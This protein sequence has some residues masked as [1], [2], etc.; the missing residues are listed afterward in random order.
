MKASECGLLDCISKPEQFVVPIYQRSYSWTRE[1]CNQLLRDIIRAGENDHV[2]TH[3]IGA[4]VYIEKGL[5]QVS[6]KEPNLIIDGQQRLTTT[7]LLLAA[8]AEALGEE[9]D[10][11]DLSAS[12][13]RNRLLIDNLE[14]GDRRYKLLLGET[15]REALIA[16]V[17]GKEELPA[18]H[19]VR[20]SEN[21]NFFREEIA[22][23]KR[24]NASISAIC[25]GLAKLVV[26][27][28]ALDRNQDKPQFIFESMNSTGLKLSQTDLIRNFVLMDLEHE[29][30][31]RLYK[32]YWCPMEKDF[33]QKDYKSHSDGFMRHYLTC[34][35][36]NGEIPNKERVY[37]EFKRYADRQPSSNDKSSLVKDIRTYARH[38]CAL[39]LEQRQEDSKLNAALVD[40]RELKA[41]VA[42]PF[43]L[44]LYHDYKEEGILD[45]D[46]LAEVI[47]M[48]E[49]YV[50]RRAVCG[51]P[52]GPVNK[53][54]AGFKRYVDKERYLESIKAHFLNLSVTRKFPRD[55]DFKNNIKVR[56]LYNF[57][58]RGYWLRRLENYERRNEK[59][60]IREFTIEHIMPQ[61]LTPEWKVALGDNWQKV[62]ETLLHTLGNL[63]LTGYNA[64]Y[65]N[66]SFA[67]KRGMED[68]FKDSPLRLNQS[69]R[70]VETWDEAAIERRA[71]AL[72]QAALKVWPAPELPEEVLNSYKQPQKGEIS[73]I[74]DY[75]YSAATKE[76]FEALREQIIQLDPSR[77][78]EHFRKSCISYK[79]D[80]NLVS[81]NPQKS[82]LKL[83]INVDFADISDPK[84]LCRDVADVGHW[85]TGD[86]E[87]QFDDISQLPYIMELIRQA[88]DLQS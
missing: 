21:F 9:E 88:L 32:D 48:I 46:S 77:I 29:L 26:V 67:E 68:G 24:K 62:H 6:R 22:A 54:F 11:Y 20:I 59:V 30:Q 12:K 60:A 17:S 16:I 7:S 55:E 23:Y 85:G 65:S 75:I 5:S 33:G 28:I 19:S 40:L 81:I 53:V 31:T 25:K 56:D 83:H 4:I 2:S 70:G 36:E 14:K 35:H 84:N 10:F 74:E 50:F 13:I 39:A 69:L 8:V 78:T 42:Y 57:R 38:Y 37:E 3:F 80:S 52:T 82:K 49:S 86:T 72:A 43:L 73:S 58:S 41:D 34:K 47:R 27:D 64:K 71:E 61:E 79:A 45:R 51:L 76:L 18:S 15:D 87:V 63:T 1:N 66:R 44:E